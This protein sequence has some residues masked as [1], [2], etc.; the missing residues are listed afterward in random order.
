MKAAYRMDWADVVGVLTVVW[1]LA[2]CATYYI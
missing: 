1:V 2:F